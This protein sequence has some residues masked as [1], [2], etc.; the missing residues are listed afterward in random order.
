M[1]IFGRKPYMGA[2]IREAGNAPGMA[3]LLGRPTGEPARPWDEQLPQQ[4]ASPIPQSRGFFGGGLAGKLGDIGAILND[5]TPPGQEQ[6]QQ[7]NQL[8]LRAQ[9]EQQSKQAQYDYELAHPKP[10]APNDTERDYQFWQQRLTPEQFQQWLAN[11]VYSPPHFGVVDGVPAMIGG[12][13]GNE[14]PPSAP[15]GKLTPLG[16]AGPQAPRPFP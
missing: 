8:L 1:G 4:Q 7:L 12:Y 16:G 13:G 10:N 2:Q 9:I 15:V 5:Q 11:R 6:Q 14:A 3:D